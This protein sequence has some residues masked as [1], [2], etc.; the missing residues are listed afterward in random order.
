MFPSYGDIL[1]IVVLGGGFLNTS[2]HSISELFIREK[3]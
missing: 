3:Q 2:I 1:R